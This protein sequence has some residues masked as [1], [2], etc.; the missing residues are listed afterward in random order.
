MNCLWVKSKNS[1]RKYV[2]RRCSDGRN[3]TLG[4]GDSPISMGYL[5]NYYEVL[6]GVNEE[7]FPIKKKPSNRE[8][9]DVA[10]AYIDAYS[11]V[12]DGISRGTLSS[13]LDKMNTLRD[14][15]RN[16]I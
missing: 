4:R 1:G 16:G 11:E 9:A 14:R 5:L 10:R 8:W 2:A 13:H 15:D 12:A 3:W 7:P 6:G